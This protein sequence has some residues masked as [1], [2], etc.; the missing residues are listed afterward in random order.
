M[1]KKKN[2]GAA[3]AVAIAESMGTGVATTPLPP[4]PAATSPSAPTTTPTTT[5]PTPSRFQEAVANATKVNWDDPDEVKAYIIAKAKEYGVD[6]DNEVFQ[7]MLATLPGDMDEATAN[8]FVLMA[9]QNPSL[10]DQTTTEYGTALEA[11]G[12]EGAFALA[13][14]VARYAA[15]TGTATPKTETQ[16]ETGW[17]RYANGV[18]V[19]PSTGQVYFE[20]NSTAPGSPTYINN[21]LDWSDEQRKVWTQKL[22]ENGYLTE[23]DKSD[24]SFIAALRAYHTNRY[25]YG[26]PIT[27]NY[28]AGAGSQAEI[29]LTAKDFQAQ[30]RN[31]IREQFRQLYGEDPTAAEL[32]HWTQYITHKS[33]AIQKELVKKGSTPSEALSVAATEAEELFI[34]KIEGTPEAEALEN[35]R[36]RDSLTEAVYITRGLGA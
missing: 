20:P 5:T 24:E 36:L 27:S 17:I 32:E 30:I 34:E 1:A 4:T 28:A 9:V 6:V 31:D 25:V 13:P 15:V 19:D 21:A 18:L 7:L 14:G 23:D 2:E 35:T 3:E 11:S 10:L 8:S 29:T 26:R 22:V 33:I 16:P 12:F